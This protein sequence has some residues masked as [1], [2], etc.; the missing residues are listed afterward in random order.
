VL[1]ELLLHRLLLLQRRHLPQVLQQPRLLLQ[2]LLQ[3]LLPTLLVTQQQVRLR[4]QANRAPVVQFELGRWGGLK[5]FSLEADQDLGVKEAFRELFVTEIFIVA[6]ANLVDLLLQV[7]GR[8][9]DR[10]AV[11][12]VPLP[13]VLELVVA[14][15]VEGTLAL[16]TLEQGLLSADL[17]T[18]CRTGNHLLYHLI[19]TVISHS[20]EKTSK[21]I[22]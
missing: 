4:Q 18:R 1:V 8:G 22:A 20:R 21:T 10:L 6:F 12:L 19:S 11:T 17:A 15:T 5:A 7:V 14:R 13:P 16:A 9:T 2:V 3:L